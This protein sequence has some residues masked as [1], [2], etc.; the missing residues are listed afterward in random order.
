MH[1]DMAVVGVSDCLEFVWARDFLPEKMAGKHKTN[2]W[3]ALLRPP[4]QILLSVQYSTDF[5]AVS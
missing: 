4:A 2:C 5:S 1:A 3:C